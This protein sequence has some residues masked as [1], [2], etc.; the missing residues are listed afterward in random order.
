VIL[1]KSSGTYK[2]A[3][4][5]MK[6]NYWDHALRDDSVIKLIFI[7]LLLPLLQVFPS[8]LL[9]LSLSLS[10]SFY[11]LCDGHKVMSFTQYYTPYSQ[12]PLMVIPC[13]NTGTKSLQLTNHKL[14]P[15]KL[16]AKINLTFLGVDFLKSW[17]FFYKLKAITCLHAMFR[18]PT[19]LL[20]F[21]PLVHPATFHGLVTAY[22]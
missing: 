19:W 11:F 7:S 12:I 18:Y 22:F 10:L 13:P 3:V 9:F 6:V 17:I 1:V 20:P 2:A 21:E 8:P 14:K 4:T 15:L 5:W 16:C